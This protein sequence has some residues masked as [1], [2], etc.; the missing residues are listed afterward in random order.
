MM[1]RH[2]K[3]ELGGVYKTGL[4]SSGTAAESASPSTLLLYD[5]HFAG[6]DMGAAHP[7][8]PERFVACLAALKAASPSARATCC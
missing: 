8:S 5:E 2:Y 1:N 6:H 3:R 7:E 4:S